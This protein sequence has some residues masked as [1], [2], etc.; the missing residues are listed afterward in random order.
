IKPGR[1][2][3]EENL[4][5]TQAPQVLSYNN[6]QLMKNF[7]QTNVK[8]AGFRQTLAQDTVNQML[9]SDYLSSLSYSLSY[10]QQAAA[11]AAALA[12]AAK[13]AAATPTPTPTQ[14]SQPFTFSRD[15]SDDESPG[16]YCPNRTAVFIKALLDDNPCI[17]HV[18]I[19]SRWIVYRLR[20][21]SS[22]VI[23]RNFDKNDRYLIEYGDSSCTQ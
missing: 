20:D 11:Q 7:V 15:S 8:D 3:S 2:E 5:C 6:L 16:S 13:A 18:Y 23:Y 4:G 9:N 12:A 21:Y 10:R 22:K 14:T 1:R 19:P 17:E